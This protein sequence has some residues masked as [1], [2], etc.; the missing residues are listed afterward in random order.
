MTLLVLLLA[1][2]SLQR[3]VAIAKKE[4]LETRHA[5]FIKWHHSEENRT[6]NYISFLESEVEKVN[7]Y[8]V[9]RLCG[10][11]VYPRCPKN[12]S[13]KL[14]LVCSGSMLP[15]I[16]CNYDVSAFD[17]HLYPYIPKLCDIVS[18]DI[19]NPLTTQTIYG[20]SVII[21]RLTHRIVA[22]NGTRFVVKG[23]ANFEPDPIQPEFQDVRYVVCKGE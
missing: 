10:D 8:S 18:Y 3:D 20:E 17:P 6:L 13:V 4:A 12:R 9:S 22:I 23:D 15:E 21:N 11:Y 14:R 2:V 1:F 5:N 19:A 16:F 7:R